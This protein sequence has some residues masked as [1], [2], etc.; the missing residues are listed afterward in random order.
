MTAD[1]L[2]VIG[3]LAAFALGI[4]PEVLRLIAAN[5]KDKRAKEHPSPPRQ[6]KEAGK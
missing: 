6:P 1:A 5:A 2:T 3:M 4:T